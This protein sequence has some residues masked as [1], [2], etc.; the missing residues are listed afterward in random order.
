MKTDDL[1]DALVADRP[2]QEP[3]PGRALARSLAVGVP[4]AL[5]LMLAILGVR[6]DIGEAMGGWRFP[7]K[8]ATM[9]VLAAT[10]GWLA[11]R[12]AYPTARTSLSALLVPAVLIVGGLAAE[13]L[14]VPPADWAR[15]T[16][17]HNALACLASIPLF[18]LAPLAAALLAL[19]S[20]A[21]ANPRLAGALAGL[22][23]GGI[24]ATF[25]GLH[26]FDDSPFF[27]V[28]WYTIAIG[29]VTLIGSILGNRF[30]RW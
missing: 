14:L 22:L 26:C 19:R 29:F 28:V 23:A 10:A 27:V 18:S 3:P 5:L 20:A 1:I 12:A 15:I 11:W 25:Y 24:G 9:T 13:T 2:A 17:G 7:L 6:P 30:L 8:I 21:P 16:L 4:V